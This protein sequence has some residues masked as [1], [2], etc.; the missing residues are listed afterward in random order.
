MTRY[1]A[2]GEPAGSED[3]TTFATETAAAGGGLSAARILRV[4][5]QRWWIVLISTVVV[6]GAAWMVIPPDV[7]L[8]RATAVVLLDDS[9][10]E[11][12]GGIDGGSTENIASIEFMVSQEHV[13]RSRA[14][15]GDVVD[16]ELL[17]LHPSDPALYPLMQEVTIG[18]RE[19]IDTLWLRF[20]GSEY[21]ASV[22]D[23]LVRGRYGKPVEIAGLRFTIASA[24]TSDTVSVVVRPREVAIEQ[25]LPGL[26]ATPRERTAIIDIHYTGVYPDRTQRIV[27][28]IALAYQAHNARGSQDAARRRRE[29]I[30]AQWLLAE[31]RLAQAQGRLSAF[32]NSGRLYSAE[33]RLSQEQTALLE[34]ESQ[35]QQIDV[36]RRLYQSFLTRVEDADADQIDAELRTLASAPGLTTGPLLTELF[37]RFSEF[38]KER[39]QLLAEGRSLTHPDV[40][41]LT[42]L[43]NSS[44]ASV[45]DAARTQLASLD[46]QLNAL[47]ERYDRSAAT[48]RS[49]PNS[50]TEE[51]RLEQEV[52]AATSSATGLESEYQRA[53]ITEAVDVGQVKILDF[54]AAAMPLPR[55]RRSQM[56]AVA[57]VLALILG[58]V[59]AMLLEVTNR[60]VRWRGDMEGVV[61][62]PGLGLIPQIANGH[63][64]SRISRALHRRNG[65]GTKEHRDR[66][67]RAA[68]EAYRVLRTNLLF[69]RPDQDLKT[70]IVTSAA[71]EEGK[72][73]TAANLAASFARQEMR[74]LLID[75]DLRRPRLHRLFGVDDRPGLVD[76]LLGMTS[77][78]AA[79][80]ETA[81]DG[82]TLMPRGIYDERAME[83]LGGARFKALLAEF[84]ERYDMVIL[85]APPVL[86]AADSAAIAA[87]MDGALLVVRAGQTSRSAARQAMHQL[88]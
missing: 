36:E 46:L 29:F 43:M 37:T 55:A 52:V 58:V 69:Q 10:Q 24:P 21:A 65:N 31:Q 70:L 41:R 66:S 13:I 30:E 57:F 39:E 19:R 11:L 80:R 47:N 35:R 18:T 73:T 17:Q 64:G 59:A 48:I 85:D 81:V 74:V 16:R 5:S 84:R 34:L 45:V 2:E 49:L 76:L 77:A 40:E 32:R 82:L 27:N 12:T 1:F 42:N 44:R 54:A 7:Q 72:T 67:V 79:S 83:M 78:H 56:L 8:Y 62:I 15:V 53:R 50:Q 88:Q 22:G 25:L 61:T 71:S 60:S 4:L 3:A 20:A 63:G 33:E 68:T 38:K 6:F 51:S 9:R 75:C 87:I 86:V 28:A 26:I 14:V 23:V